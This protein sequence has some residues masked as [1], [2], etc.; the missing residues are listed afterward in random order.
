MGFRTARLFSLLPVILLWLPA[1]LL[2]GCGGGGTGTP[3]S[4][5]AP[6]GLTY[7]SAT[8]MYRATLAITPNEAS[9]G[10]GTPTGW[11]VLPA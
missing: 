7:E 6:S 11:A 4:P 8:A 10:G 9:V 2:A 1:G 5:N 3:A